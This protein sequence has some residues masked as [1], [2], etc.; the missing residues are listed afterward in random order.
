[1]TNAVRPRL[2]SSK[3]VRKVERR[4]RAA[5]ESLTTGGLVVLAC[6]AVL[7]TS[8]GYMRVRTVFEVRDYEIEA[9]RLHGLTT[10][11]RDEIKR[12][13]ARL[14]DLK[15]DETLREAALGA[16]GMIEPP[17]A[18]VGLLE[19]DA[20]R[21]AAVEAAERGA[22]LELEQRRLEY[23]VAGWEVK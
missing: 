17:A 11:S 22:A 20:G 7:A 2:R 21:V 10:V 1:M 3:R 18:A 6:L 5:P 19:V 9:S 16:F 23:Q 4:E 8:L 12:L 13:E 15:R 14:G